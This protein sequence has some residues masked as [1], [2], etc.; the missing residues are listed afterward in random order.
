[1]KKLNP[2]TYLI[3]DK[4]LVDLLKDPTADGGAEIRIHELQNEI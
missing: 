2:I 1:M 3:E 4:M